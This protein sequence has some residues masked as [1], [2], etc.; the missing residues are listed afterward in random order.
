M[1]G[2]P[3]ARRGESPAPGQ[4]TVEVRLIAP[5]PVLDAALAALAQVDGWQLN[6]RRPAR[7]GERAY[8]TLIVTVPP[9]PPCPG[10]RP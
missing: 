10:P 6:G 5:G 1:T 7:R 9:E 2:R 8:G 4:G 3:P